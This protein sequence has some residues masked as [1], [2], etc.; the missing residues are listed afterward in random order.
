[1]KKRQLVYVPEIHPTSF[2]LLF[3][4][5]TR[6][7]SWSIR[8]YIEP[9]ACRRYAMLENSTFDLRQFVRERCEA[10]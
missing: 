7:L 2:V 1:M 10:D 6:G 3:E 5:G 4:K 9:Q 8:D